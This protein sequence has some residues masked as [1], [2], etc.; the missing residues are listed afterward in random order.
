MNLL[1]IAPIRRIGRIHAPW[2]TAN[3]AAGLQ[4]LLQCLS[5]QEAVITRPSTAQ[6]RQLTISWDHAWNPRF[7]CTHAHGHNSPVR[8]ELDTKAN[9]TSAQLYATLCQM[10][11]ERRNRDLLQYWD[12]H[13]KITPNDSFNSIDESVLEVYLSVLRKVRKH[14]GQEFADYSIDRYAP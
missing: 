2:G 13:V 7:F 1:A 6:T 11:R 12:D 14:A 3:S 9:N 5:G 8:G 4:R 10:Q